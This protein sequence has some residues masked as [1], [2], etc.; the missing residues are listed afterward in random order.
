MNNDEIIK[1]VFGFV[2]G[3]SVAGNIITWL[4]K[5]GKCILNQK[6]VIIDVTAASKNY[7]V[8]RF[9]ISLQF[10]NMSG[11]NVI[12]KD[13]C[14]TFYNGVDEEGR[15]L[16]FKDFIVRPA[17]SIE[18]KQVKCLQFDSYSLMVEDLMLNQRMIIDRKAYMEVHYNLKG[19]D[20][21]LIISGNDIELN[22]DYA[23]YGLPDTY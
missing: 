7:F 22:D 23:P 15:E 11:Y 8:K 21:K 4:Q 18:P 12:L 1:I 5:R 10:I 20:T 6:K 3:G 2:L 13:L 19:K 14:A 16:Y 17:G 9:S